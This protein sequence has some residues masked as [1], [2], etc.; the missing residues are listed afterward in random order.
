MIPTII[1]NYERI[2]E[3]DNELNISLYEE[4][5]NF[6]NLIS[7]LK[8]IALYYPE[9]NYINEKL[10]IKL[11]EYKAKLL[12]QINLAKNHGIY[13]FA[14]KYKYILNKANCYDETI[15]IFLKLNMMHFLLNWEND[16]IKILNIFLVN[17]YKK[18]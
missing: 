9:Y 4:N 3:I 17:E 7:P 13:G 15:L 11:V 14:I 12:N 2:N 6:S 10:S 5:I 18:K 8:P 1:I 16:N